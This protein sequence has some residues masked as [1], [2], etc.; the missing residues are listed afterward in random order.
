M[1]YFL[2][3]VKFE[4]NRLI[5]SVKR[6]RWWLGAGD[7]WRGQNERMNVW[8]SKNGH[9]K[10]IHCLESCLPI[11]LLHNQLIDPINQS[12]HRLREL[13]NRQKA[14]IWDYTKR[15]LWLANQKEKDETDH[16]IVRQ[17]V[18]KKEGRRKDKVAGQ[19][20]IFRKT[21]NIDLKTFTSSE[22]TF[23]CVGVC[24]WEW[25]RTRSG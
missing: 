20:E 25:R 2:L 23:V 16:K 6:M 15:L 17:I 12:S 7:E 21:K 10:R 1:I 13:R 11:I 4:I 19:N 14:I 5:S 3:K 8:R 24:K 22:W 9:E 18:G